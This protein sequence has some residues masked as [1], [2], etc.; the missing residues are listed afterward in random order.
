M[1]VIKE[2]IEYRLKVD[3]HDP[4]ADPKTA[5][6]IH[7]L[8]Y[9]SLPERESYDAVILAVAHTCFVK[10]GPQKFRK[11]GKDK[12]VFYDLKSVF[13]ANESDLRL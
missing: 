3:V 7:G 13:K 6:D 8:T 12:H 10:E 11:F 5:Q 9:V 2:L 4:L 1:D